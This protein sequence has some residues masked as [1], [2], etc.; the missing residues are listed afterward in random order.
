ML[1]ARWAHV[2]SNHRLLGGFSCG[3]TRQAVDQDDPGPQV[4][5]VAGPASL[6]AVAIIWAG[7]LRTDPASHFALAREPFLGTRGSV[8]PAGRGDHVVRAALRRLGVVDTHH[9]GHPPAVRFLPG[10]QP[11]PHLPRAGGGPGSGRPQCSGAASRSPWHRRTGP[12]ASRTCTARGPGRR[13]TPGCRRRRP[14]RTAPAAAC[15]SPV[16]SGGR[17]PRARPRTSRGLPR[18]R[19]AGVRE[20][21]CRA[22]GSDKAASA[23]PQFPAPGR[24][25]APSGFRRFARCRARRRER[26]QAA[27]SWLRLVRTRTALDPA[28]S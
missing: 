1:F 14:S 10:R 28:R 25:H 15:R 27:P 5:R 22:A 20:W 4:L 8:P 18:S 12:A 6:K 11:G 23:G 7:W 26:E 19:P 24:R 16:R 13:R 17:P 2:G 3:A 9:G 21:E